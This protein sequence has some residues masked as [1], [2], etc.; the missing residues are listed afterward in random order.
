MFCPRCDSREWYT[1]GDYLVLLVTFVIILPL[2]LLRNLGKQSVNTCASVLSKI[3]C[4]S[5]Y[6]GLRGI[7]DDM[8][9]KLFLVVAHVCVV[10]PPSAGYLGYTSGLSLL[11]MVFFLIVVSENRTFPT[12]FSLLRQ[13]L[14]SFP[15]SR[16]AAFIYYLLRNKIRYV[17][18]FTDETQ[19]LNKKTFSKIQIKGFVSFSSR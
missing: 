18:Y 4:I 1:N 13:F 2:S 7:G 11:C 19:M 8:H 6:G 17:L 5:T 9:R 14:M 10:L 12:C 3:Q 15:H 16:S